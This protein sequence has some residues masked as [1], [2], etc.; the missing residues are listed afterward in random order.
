MNFDLPEKLT[1]PCCNTDIYVTGRDENGCL[2]IPELDINNEPYKKEK[3]IM[4]KALC[5]DYSNKHRS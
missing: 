3:T 1:C 4:I 5:I 2:I